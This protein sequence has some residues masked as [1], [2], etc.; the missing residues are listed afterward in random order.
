MPKIRYASHALST[1]FNQFFVV[2]LVGFIAFIPGIALAQD[3]GVAEG[4]TLETNPKDRPQIVTATV[5]D[6]ISPSTPILISPEDGSTVTTSLPTFVWSQSSDNVGV[7]SYTL[8]LDGSILYSDIPT[9]DTE[10]SLYILD[11]NSDTGYFS[12]TVKSAIS[13]GSHTWKITA[14]DAAGNLASSV[15]WTFNI[16]SQAPSF[17]ITDVGSEEVSISAQDIDTVP[18]QPIE[19]SENSPLLVGTGEANSEVDVTIYTSSSTLDSS[20]FTIDGSGNWTLQLGIL[21][22]DIIIYLD[23]LITDP[24]GN[25]SILENVP[26][27]IKS[28]YIQIPPTAA[29]SLPPGAPPAEEP[30]ALEVPPL[31]IKVPQPQEAVTELIQQVTILLPAPLRGYLSLSPVV[32]RPSLELLILSI[33]ALILLSLPILISGA[34]LF[35]ILESKLHWTTLRKIMIAIGLW[36]ARQSGIVF[37]TTLQ[38][39]IPYCA[40]LFIGET[41]DKLPVREVV[42]T[43]AAGYYP[44]PELQ[45]GKYRVHVDFK[46]GMFPSSEVKPA[47]VAWYNFYQNQTIIV[48]QDSIIEPLLLPV[49]LRQPAD[50]VPRT[51]QSRVLHTLAYTR[52]L[53][54]MLFGVS[55]LVTIL[56]PSIFNLAAIG[57]YCGGLLHKLYIKQTSEAIAGIQNEDGQPLRWALFRALDPET[58]STILVTYSDAE[59]RCFGRIDLDTTMVQVVYHNAQLMASEQLTI[60]CTHL[61]KEFGIMPSAENQLPLTI[62]LN[63]L[64]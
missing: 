36:P 21:P 23:F 17:I 37:E 33:L 47:H 38:R 18:T 62:T 6:F 63:N 34:M 54:L 3:G 27:I 16:D 9:N 8:T 41:Q 30:P 50:Y 60:N 25:T 32:L 52:P 64:Q 14:Y 42:V 11:Y 7:D 28:Q 53:S 40:V 1:L 55:F 46:P 56:Y 31:V 19:L 29:P 48:Q 10:N 49:D 20:S 12:L 24:A 51:W 39:P 58:V 44:K 15:T 45:A 35:G 61:D 13:N 43:D 26:I 2:V 5:P 4:E 59:G 57:L 22:R